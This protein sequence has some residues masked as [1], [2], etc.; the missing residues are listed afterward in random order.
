[1][2][3][4]ASTRR[5]N[6]KTRS[7]SSKGRSLQKPNGVISPRVAKVGGEKFGIVCIDPAKNRSEL[8]MADYFGVV[9]GI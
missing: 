5:K 1:M 3:A 2:S 7:K 8:I 9:D 4:T 6:R